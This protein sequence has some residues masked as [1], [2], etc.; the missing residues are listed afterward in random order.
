MIGRTATFSLFA[1]CM[2]LAALSG[3]ASFKPIPLNELQF[4]ERQ[5]TQTQEEIEV[6]VSVMTRQEAR[7]AFGKT[8]DKKA[9]QPVW[10]EIKNNSNQPLW[11]MLHGID[12]NYFSAREA[13]TLVHKGVAVNKGEIDDYFDANGIGPLIPAGG[14]SSGF[15][16]S[17]LKQGTKEVRVRLLGIEQHLDFDFFVTVP[18][19]KADWQRTDFETL[20]RD[21]EIIEF[22]DPAEFRATLEQFM[23]CTTRK[24]G[25]GSGDPI[26][27]VVLAPTEESLLAFVRAGWDETAIITAGSAWQT[28]KSFLTGG[29][30]KNSPISSLY[31]FERPQDLSLQKARD[32]IN[33][34]NHLRLWVTPWVFQGHIVLLG[35]IS[36]DIGVF[37]TTRT[38]NLTSHAIDS[39]IDETRNYILED[40]AAAQK[41]A[42]YGFVNGVGYT[43]SD[44]PKENLLGTPWW[45]DG[46]RVVLMLSDTPV[47]AEE[48]QFLDW[49][50]R[51]SGSE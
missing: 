39:E 32:T 16:F 24:D 46:Q 40:L 29:E 18:G 19:L 17:N 20:Y 13:A 43:S 44:D 34:R 23:C 22:E 28:A 50:Q 27:M 35:G 3:C 6:S 48:M 45:T 47:P 4:L 33:E 2:L 1:T 11:L 42:G 51:I 41:I 15:V 9:I 7:A 10:L 37:W 26:N 14:S 21:D 25:S 31:V 5:Q 38:W 30:Y 12:P 49:T 8:L 36:R